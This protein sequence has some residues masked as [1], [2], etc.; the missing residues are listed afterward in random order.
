MHREYLSTP[1]QLPAS[2]YTSAAAGRV[3]RKL[4]RYTTLLYNPKS[5]LVRSP[6]ALVE[7]QISTLNQGTSSFVASQTHINMHALMS[8]FLTA[9]GLI[10]ISNLSVCF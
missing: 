7:S 2:A 4:L 8:C 10:C 5:F 3:R 6:A 9:V 1:D